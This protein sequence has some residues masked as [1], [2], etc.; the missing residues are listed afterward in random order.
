MLDHARA[1][2][3][4]WKPRISAKLFPASLPFAFAFRRPFMKPNDVNA[5][6]LVGLAEL[7]E[8][9]TYTGARLRQL[10]AEGVVVKQGRNR[11]ALRASI[12]GI[13]ERLRRDQHSPPAGSLAAL[14]E[15]ELRARDRR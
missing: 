11:Y 12:R 15:A 7:S 6:P 9:T 1:K 4:A 13:I 2:P 14:I 3:P 8:W 5:D 10:A